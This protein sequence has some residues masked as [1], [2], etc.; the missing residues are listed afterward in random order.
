MTSAVFQ[1]PDLKAEQKDKLVVVH[2]K[3]RVQI[4]IVLQLQLDQLIRLSLSFWKR[5]LSFIQVILKHG[6]LQ[7]K[8]ELGWQIVIRLIRRLVEL[9]FLQV[10]EVV[11]RLHLWH[12]IIFQRFLHV[13]LELL[14]QL[15]LRT[16]L[17][18][19]IKQLFQT[20]SPNGTLFQQLCLITVTLEAPTPVAW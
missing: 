6:R 11:H 12:I 15:Q 14:P 17:P 7:Q 8:M 2:N 20:S 4:V 13:R 16:E 18:Q 19:N 1:S 5:N 10:V 3:M 9:R